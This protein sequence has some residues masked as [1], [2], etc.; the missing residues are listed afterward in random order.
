[1]HIEL[2][3]GG[4]NEWIVTVSDAVTTTHRVTVLPE[5]VQRLAKG[6]TADELIKKSFEFLL[7]REP[8]TSILRSFE[9]PLIGHY[10]PEYEHEIQ[11]TLSG[12]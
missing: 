11:R 2:S 4:R 7:E 6:R 9:L 3:Q 12:K 10:F 1:M 5:T 8:N